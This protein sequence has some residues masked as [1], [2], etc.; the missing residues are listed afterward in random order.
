MSSSL[1]RTPLLEVSTKCVFTNTTFVSP[2]RGAGRPEG[3]YFMERLI[4]YA[5]AR[6]RHRPARTAPQEPDRGQ[7]DPV[8]V[9]LRR[10]LRQRRLPGHPEGGP[11]GRRLE[12]LQPSASARARS[13]ASCAASGSAAILEVTA[14][15]NKEMGG[16]RFDADGGVTIVTGT[17]DYGQGHEYAVRAGAERT[18]RRSVRARPPAAGR[19]RRTGRRRR[20]RRLALDDEFRHGDRG[21]RRPK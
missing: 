21:S 14:P 6:D 7:G 9:R 5:A 8:Q 3:N 16:I 15:A 10:D 19:Q 12:G 11:G 1:Y 20:H 13:T 4:D 18:A 17:L 2:Y